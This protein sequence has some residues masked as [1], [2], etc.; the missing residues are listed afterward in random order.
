MKKR[1]AAQIL[2]LY[3]CL[4]CEPPTEELRAD[5]S[6][7]PLETGLFVEYQVRESHYSVAG[8]ARET[9]YYLKERCGDTFQTHNGGEH[10]RIER[11]RKNSPTAAWLPD[12]VWSARLLPDRAIRT[13]NNRAFI[14]LIFPLTS[15]TTWN[16]N[17]LNELPSELYKANFETENLSG[18]ES[19]LPRP[20]TVVQRQDSSIISLYRKSEQYAPGI[21][22]IYRENTALEYCQ[23]PSCLGSGRINSG[24]RK[25]QQMV[26]Y[27]KE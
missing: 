14:K 10:V 27:G 16:G 8:P 5:Y 7:F 1:L 25:I 20:L 9:T 15:Q 24:H 23:E 12:S 17:A 22:L 3:I 26:A 18:F 4:S 21:G 19:S 13:E 2:V 11:F 6:Y